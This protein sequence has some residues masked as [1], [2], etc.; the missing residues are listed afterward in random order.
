VTAGDVPRLRQRFLDAY[1]HPPADDFEARVGAYEARGYLEV[2][3]YV[4]CG[5][6]VIPDPDRYEFLVGSAESCAGAVA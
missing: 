6:H 4:F 5:L 2:A 1:A 3:H